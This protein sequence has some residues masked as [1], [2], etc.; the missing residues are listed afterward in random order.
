MF[1]FLS[2]VNIVPILFLFMIFLHII[3]DYLV[4]NDFMAKYK[5][6]TLSYGLRDVGSIPTES[7]YLDG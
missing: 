5:Q 1:D 3:A 7:I 2:N 4:Q 6:R